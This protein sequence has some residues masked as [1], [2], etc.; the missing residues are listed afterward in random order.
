VI[1]YLWRGVS[2]RWLT[3]A[4]GRFGTSGATREIAIAKAREYSGNF[5]IVESVPPSL[6][7]EAA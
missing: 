6:T 7:K 2:G 3:V 5:E 1:L 4:V